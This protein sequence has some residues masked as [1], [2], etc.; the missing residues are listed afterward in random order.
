MEIARL[1]TFLAPFLPV[2]MET[3][4]AAFA[5]LIEKFGEDAWHRAKAMWTQ[6]QPEV[7]FYPDLKMAAT[8]LIA[9]PDSKSRQSVLQEELEALLHEKPT[10]ARS[11]TQ[12]LQKNTSTGASSPHITQT[13]TGNQ[14]QVIGQVSGGPVLGNVTGTIIIGNSVSSAATPG[15]TVDATA[16]KTPVSVKTILVLT[17]N[18]KGTTPLRLGEEVR[19]LQN[20]LERSP[21]RDRFRLEQR[22]AVTVKDVRRALLDCHP[23]IVHFSGHGIGVEPTPEESLST[24]KASV[25]SGATTEP[26]GLL[27]E[28]ETGQP[29]LVSATA[30][31]NLFSLFA[32][33]VECVVLN[34]CYSV[35]QAN[36]IAEEIPYVVGMKR[37]IGDRAAIEFAIGFYDALLAGRDVEFAYK[38][39]C[40]AIEM[41][42]IPEQLTPVL[43][44]NSE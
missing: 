25:V 3:N 28:D 2:L 39:G 12:I 11:L 31:A 13:T 21:H 10:L 20:G 30:I 17:A 1:T 16:E 22:W 26:E 4:E 38:L 44:Q 27:F 36:A 5:D 14:N 32:D 15:L 33:Q 19:Q 24:R 23:Q 35:T 7:E 29:K 18:P 34:A 41:E 40:N 37:A 8:Q 9:K 42:N 6:L 43:K